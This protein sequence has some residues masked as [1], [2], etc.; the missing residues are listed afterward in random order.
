MQAAEEAVAG[1]SN[2]S[3]VKSTEKR[4]AKA[5]EQMTAARLKAQKMFAKF[6]LFVQQANEE[7]RLHH[8]RDIPSIC[9][10]FE[11][12]E[13]ERTEELRNKLLDLQRIYND[14][15]GANTNAQLSIVANR[16]EIQRLCNCKVACSKRLWTK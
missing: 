9:S 3:L 16:G 2:P 8:T 12:L 4:S 10:A 5:A 13:L 15:L 1:A 11:M 7:I 14:W 6:E